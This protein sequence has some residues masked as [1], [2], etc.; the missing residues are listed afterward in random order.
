MRSFIFPKVLRAS[1]V[2]SA[3]SML[4][5]GCA[6]PGAPSTS[7]N[8]GST[9]VHEDSA[10]ARPDAGGDFASDANTKDTSA[11]ETTQLLH[12]LL[13]TWRLDSVQLYTMRD[14]Q[15]LDYPYIILGE[16][17][18]AEITYFENGTFA[19]MS[20][21]PAAHPSGTGAYTVVDRG[22]E[23]MPDE[24]YQIVHVYDADSLYV[25]KNVFSFDENSLNALWSTYSALDPAPTGILY[26]EEWLKVD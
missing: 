7:P 18:Q 13:G 8:D 3:S 20:A 4:G 1:F 5:T 25:S 22:P 24:R 2:V 12:T 6:G 11:T 16:D 10:L 19:S 9:I 17:A 21:E 14:G 26:D 23:F 15:A